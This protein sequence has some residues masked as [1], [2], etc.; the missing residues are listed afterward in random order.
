[1]IHHKKNN[2]QIPNPACRF[3]DVKA[4]TASSFFG[5]SRKSPTFPPR[6]TKNLRRTLTQT[7]TNKKNALYPGAM[8]FLG[9]EF[10]VDVMWWLGPVQALLTGPKVS[11]FGT[12]PKQPDKFYQPNKKDMHWFSIRQ[13]TTRIYT[14][15]FFVGGGSTPLFSSQ[16]NARFHL[17]KIKLNDFNGFHHNFGG[18]WQLWWPRVVKETRDRLVLGCFFDCLFFWLV[19]KGGDQ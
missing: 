15:C 17:S 5:E 2:P 9:C 4:L 18:L 8:S 16:L 1:M 19:G 12:K 14:P 10:G 11:R 6:G 7:K 3:F 13:K